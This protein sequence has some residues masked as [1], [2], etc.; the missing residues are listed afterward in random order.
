MCLHIEGIQKWK[1]ALP[2]LMRRA[3]TIIEEK[4]E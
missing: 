3:I 1:G 2:N 4:I